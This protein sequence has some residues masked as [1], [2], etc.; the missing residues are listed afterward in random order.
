MRLLLLLLLVSAVAEGLRQQGGG[1]GEKRR[2]GVRG[3]QWQVPKKTKKRVPKFDYKEDFD[4]IC[5]AELNRRASL[6]GGLDQ[7]SFAGF[8]YD[9]CSRSPYVGASCFVDNGDMSFD[10]IPLEIQLVFASSVCPMLFRYKKVEC[11]E[12]LL[13][14]GT[15]IEYQEEIEELCEQVSELLES[16]RI[17]EN[18]TS[19]S[20]PS[21][22]PAFLPVAVPLDPVYNEVTVPTM[23][24][25]LLPITSPVAESPNTMKETDTPSQYIAPALKP[26][27]LEL[28]SES[29][30]S[31]SLTPKVKTNENSIVRHPG[32]VAAVILA[33]AVLILLVTTFV[34]RNFRKKTVCDSGNEDMESDVSVPSE[35]SCGY[36]KKDLDEDS[37][38]GRTEGEIEF[39]KE[40]AMLTAQHETKRKRKRSGHELEGNNDIC[41]DRNDQDHYLLHP[42]EILHNAP[43]EKERDQAHLATDPLT[44]VH[45]TPLLREQNQTMDFST[46]I[47]RNEVEHQVGDST[48]LEE[49]G[50]SRHGSTVDSQKASVLS[51]AKW[52]EGQK[53]SP[54]TFD[55]CPANSEVASQ[56][57][58]VQ[59]QKIL[60]QNP[61]KA[62]SDL[63]LG[64]EGIHAS[65][66]TNSLKNSQRGISTDDDV[67]S[68]FDE[69]IDCVED[70][71]E[72]DSISNSDSEAPYLYAVDHFGVTS[73]VSDDWTEETVSIAEGDQVLDVDEDEDRS[74]PCKDWK[75]DNEV[76]APEELTAIDDFEIRVVTLH[77]P[78]S[79]GMHHVVAGP[80][81]ASPAASH[82]RVSVKEIAAAI[83]CTNT[84]TPV[85]T[86][87]VREANPV[88][89]FDF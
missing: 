81:V 13:S 44:P 29:N 7:S 41:K 3:L 36:A 64:H 79:L 56:T 35:K 19:T 12:E 83:N 39:F 77:D 8:L 74:I 75:S 17:L 20:Q 11:L 72:H 48:T 10:A 37:S 58:S 59:S 87:V 28:S 52:L 32:L 23:P 54:K 38:F 68:G 82:D 40:D 31:A 30:S 70:V 89:S 78:S 88:K 49:I 46:S 80:V 47:A 33:V 67:S 14:Q 53:V 65:S 9:Y 51:N 76:E 25:T 16:T 2:R 6:N 66:D 62:K 18:V 71:E 21:Q 55:E 85:P 57:A 86:S 84:S 45:S 4:S 34:V 5:I 63:S 26:D 15:A 60:P 73:D 1:G 22:R 24:P 61:A 43:V 69:S 42:L 50:T 27:N